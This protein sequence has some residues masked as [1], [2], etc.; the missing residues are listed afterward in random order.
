MNK[1]II[2]KVLKEKVDNFWKSYEEMVDDDNFE[3]EIKKC[4]KLY[5]KIDEVS[6]EEQQYIM[7]MINL[8]E[9]VMDSIKCDSGYW[10]N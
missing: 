7:S 6:E 4:D 1:D 5:D 8:C 9:N 10:K 2:N 3:K